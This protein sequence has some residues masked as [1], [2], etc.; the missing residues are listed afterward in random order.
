MTHS[1]SYRGTLAAA[2]ALLLCA[3][4]TAFAANADAD[5]DAEATTG[6][7]TPIHRTERVVVSAKGTAADVPDALATEVVL[8][9]D[10]I[11]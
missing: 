11:A 5:A 6:D 10:A 7:D 2:I 3:A 1:L 9:E 4:P 8:V